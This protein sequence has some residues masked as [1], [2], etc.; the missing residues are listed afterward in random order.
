MKINTNCDFVTIFGSCEFK[1]LPD[2]KVISLSWL[3]S[4]R[5]EIKAT[6]TE[7]SFILFVYAL[8]YDI[9]NKLNKKKITM[10]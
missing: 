10:T 2:R 1:L 6:L 3:E 9:D 7:Y 8:C 4:E 5:C